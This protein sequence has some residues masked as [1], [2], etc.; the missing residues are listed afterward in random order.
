MHPRVSF[1]IQATVVGTAVGAVGEEDELG[2]ADTDGLP[3]GASEML[4]ATEAVG[5]LV[6]GLGDLVLGDFLFIILW[7]LPLIL[8]L[9]RTLP[10]P[11]HMWLDL[12]HSREQQSSFSTHLSPTNPSRQVGDMEGTELGWLLGDFA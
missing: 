11:P 2:R 9:G 5:G 10:C 7:F 12:W 6:L 1:S 8:R 3:V 4:G